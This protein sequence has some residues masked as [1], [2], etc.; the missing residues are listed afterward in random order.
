MA[1]ALLL[2]ATLPARVTGAADLFA[3]YSVLDLGGD[4]AQG[5]AAGAAAS[6]RGGTM[7]LGLDAS[8][9]FGGSAPV[10]ELG[11]F[12]SLALAARASARVSPF[13][14]LRAGGA[15]RREQVDVFG[16]SIGADGVC[17]GSCPYTLGPSAEGGGGLDVRL[18]GRWHLRLEAAYRARRLSG[19][20]EHGLRLSGG[21]ARR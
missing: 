18:S 1:A 11:L 3:G 13:V 21:I 7:R 16:V 10:R 17:D 6:L 12:A 19:T 4:W 8:A 15:A 2:S 20:V 14:V 9:H 5:G